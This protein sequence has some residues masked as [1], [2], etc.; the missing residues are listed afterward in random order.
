MSKALN[1]LKWAAIDKFGQQLLTFILFLVIASRLTPEEFGIYA[2]CM[3]TSSFAILLQDL[4][5]GEAIIKLPAKKDVLNSAFFT[6]VGISIILTGVMIAT[7]DKMSELYGLPEA[8]K[9][10]KLI[11]ISVFIKSFNIV[12]ESILRKKL[13]FKILAI[14]TSVAKLISSVIAVVLVFLDFGVYSLVFQSISFAVLSVV[15]IWFLADWKPS[16]SINYTTFKR[17]LKVSFS[18]LNAKIVSV[19][20]SKT[21]EFVIGYFFGPKALGLYTVAMNFTKRIFELLNGIILGYTYPLL[22]SKK[23]ADINATFLRILKHLSYISLLVF[24]GIF[25]YNEE[26]ISVAL[27]EKWADAGFYLKILS[28]FAISKVISGLTAQTLKSINKVNAVFR[29]KIVETSTKIIVF[30]AFAYFTNEFVTVTVAYLF[31]SIYKI[32]V[33]GYYLGK[34]S[35]IRSFEFVKIYFE[36]LLYISPIFIGIF[37]KTGNNLLNLAIAIGLSLISLGIYLY[38]NNDLKMIVRNVVKVQK[39]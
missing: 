23:R 13:K 16:F 9:Y 19:L 26:L 22:S 18:F 32:F 36:R 30:F 34:Y 20:D 2:F 39:V 35:G 5:I 15:L 1:G 28:I 7:A 11:S 17:V 14:R 8:G 12:Q 25:N 4:G 29:I 6:N 33:F 21:D 38:L 10:V 31:T 24:M 3:L 37:I 27:G